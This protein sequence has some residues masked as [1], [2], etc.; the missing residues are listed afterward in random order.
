VL[1]EREQRV[2]QRFGLGRQIGLGK[3]RRAHCR[4]GEFLAQ[5]GGGEFGLELAE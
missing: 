2:E 1:D 4:I 3:Y 5:V